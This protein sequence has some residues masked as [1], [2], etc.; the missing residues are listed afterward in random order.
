M[1]FVVKGINQCKVLLNV[2]AFSVR[3]FLLLLCL[4]FVPAHVVPVWRLHV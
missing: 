4:L 1:Q 3:V 2:L